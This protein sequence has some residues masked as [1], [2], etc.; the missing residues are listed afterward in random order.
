MRTVLFFVLMLVGCVSVP[1]ERNFPDAPD[2]LKQS[3]D[4]LSL[5]T[6]PEP[7]MTDVLDT[8]VENYGKYHECSAK[9][10]SW[11]EWYSEQKRIFDKTK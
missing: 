6:K 9:N 3:C 2:S 11:N 4:K 8:V 7:Q 1:V 5:I 10:Q